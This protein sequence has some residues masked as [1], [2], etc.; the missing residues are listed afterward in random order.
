MGNIKVPLFKIE[1][2]KNE[3]GYTVIRVFGLE[4]LGQ[5]PQKKQKKWK[6]RDQRTDLPS[7]QR[8]DQVE[9]RVA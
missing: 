5:R 7:N 9:C 4:Q 3:D 2:R 6:W 8:M 1:P